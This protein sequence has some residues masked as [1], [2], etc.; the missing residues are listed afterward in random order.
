MQK[1]RSHTEPKSHR[2]PTACRQTVSGTISLPSPGCFSPFPHGTGSLSVAKTYLA[3]GDGPPK[4]PQGSS[5][6]AVLGNPILKPLSFHLPDFHR[7]WSGFPAD[8]PLVTSRAF[9]KRLLSTPRPRSC[10]ASGLSHTIGLG[11]FPFARRYLENRFCFLL[12]RVLR[13]FSSPRS[14]HGPMYSVHDDTGL[15]VTGFP[16]RK[17]PDQSLFG[18]SPRLIAACRVLHR[19]LA[20]RHPPSALCS[21]ATKL[22]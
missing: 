19:R 14:P 4:F 16:I 15:T 2:A 10:N 21:L 12:L 22:S 9:R 6:P 8:S 11:C 18:S 3:L 13:C 5:C 7:L 17:S 20:P 1:A